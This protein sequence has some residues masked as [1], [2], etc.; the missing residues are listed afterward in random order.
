M[1]NVNLT[2]LKQQIESLLHSRTQLLTENKLLHKK[3]ANVIQER[4]LLLNKK[5]AISKKLKVIINQLKE[6]IS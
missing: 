4:V 1:D 2:K 5:E 6:E 3:L